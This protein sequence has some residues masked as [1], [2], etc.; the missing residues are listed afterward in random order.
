M[1]HCVKPGVA[2]RGK[3][4]T[5]RYIMI[6][7]FAFALQIG[8]ARAD[9]DMITKQSPYSVAKT[10]DRLSAI[11]EKKGI[12]VFTRVDHAAG[13]KKVGLT[14][15]PAQVLIFGN[16]KLGTPLM[17]AE[18]KIGLDLPLKALAWED[19]SGKVWLGYTKP[20]ELKDRYDVEGVDKVFKKITGALDKLTSAAV[21]AE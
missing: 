3:E 5:M 8:V 6:L 21:K 19:S 13:A 14:L 18:P 1:L 2:E 7:V 4:R 16:P 9:D 11:M 20:S 17:N 12:T 15:R 10:L